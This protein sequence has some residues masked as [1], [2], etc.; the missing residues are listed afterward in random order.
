MR[1]VP[2]AEESAWAPLQKTAS[3]V[4]DSLAGSVGVEFDLEHAA[5]AAKFGRWLNTTMTW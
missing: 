5:S 4:I 3:N 1:A 2:M